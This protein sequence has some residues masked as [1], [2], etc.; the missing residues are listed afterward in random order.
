MNFIAKLLLLLDSKMTVPTNYGWFHLMFLA[1][2]IVGTVLLSLKYKDC[3]NKTFRK[4]LLIFWIVLLVLEI[5]K[6]IN[7]TFKVESGEIVADYQWYAFP[8][9][10]CSSPLYVLPFIV[11]LKDGKVRDSLIAFMSVFCIFGGI[12]V[13]IYPNDVF[14]GTI[15]I[16]IQTMVHHGSQVVLGVFCTVWYRKRFDITFRHY[17]KASIVFVTFIIVALVLNVIF[18]NLLLSMNIDETFNMFYISPY[19]P[20]TLPLLGDLIYPNVPYIVF[21]LIYI[22]GFIF[23]GAIIYLAEHYIIKLSSK[24]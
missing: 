4:I 20:C 16:N 8:F 15:G 6:Q 12:S 3:S 5:Y 13:M 21:L 24:K 14:I 10:F 1:I 19:F 11:F 17:F 7:Y 18:R 9:Q 2:V 23:V 22:I